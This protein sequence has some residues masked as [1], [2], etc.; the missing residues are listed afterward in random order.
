M[1]VIYAA[2]KLINNLRI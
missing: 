2:N 1:N